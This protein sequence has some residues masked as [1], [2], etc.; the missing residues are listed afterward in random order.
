LLPISAN[1][2]APVSRAAA[3][4]WPRAFSPRNGKHVDDKNIIDESILTNEFALML[5]V[6]EM[7]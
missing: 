3:S 1:R 5:K 7:N 4:A 6:H 2:G